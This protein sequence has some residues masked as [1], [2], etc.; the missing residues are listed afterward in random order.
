MQ[1][2]E[3]DAERKESWGTIQSVKEVVKDI[4]HRPDWITGA[5]STEIENNFSHFFQ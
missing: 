2:T 3:G 1:S 5:K 4:Q